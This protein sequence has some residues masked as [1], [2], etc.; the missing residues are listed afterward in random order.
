MKK[1]G[2]L[3]VLASIVFLAIALFLILN[4]HSAHATDN[5]LP[6]NYEQ[7]QNVANQV[8]QTPEDIKSV[9][10]T[11]L[12]QEWT[13]L[14]AKYPIGRFFLGISDWLT[15]FNFIWKPIF[16]I[17]YSFSWAFIFSFA[18]FFIIYY[19][20]YGPLSAMFDKK[21]I[22]IISSLIVA[23]LVGFSGVIKK[24]VD[25]LSFAVNNVWIA[26]LSLVL[27]IF[28]MI[29]LAK[30]DKGIKAWLTKEKEGEEKIKT[31]E[32]QQKIK[33]AGR[34]AEAELKERAKKR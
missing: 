25:L 29:F 18:I 27:A 34:V 10:Q 19:I 6:I 4:L 26:G 17:E 2:R 21:S 13:K 11:Y 23:S 1:A 14:L 5:P 3:F 12:K 22:A 28:I 20:V 30:F 9:G 8:P 24:S 7:I 32:A 31:E 15:Y 16:G 33:A